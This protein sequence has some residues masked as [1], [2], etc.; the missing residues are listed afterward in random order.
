MSD[1]DAIKKIVDKRLLNDT[2][3]RAHRAQTT[4]LRWVVGLGV[5]VFLVAGVGG[6]RYVV[7]AS[8]DARAAEERNDAQDQ[9]ILAV[10]KRVDDY[11]RQLDRMED[12][13]DRLIERQ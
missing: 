7:K 12:K 6:V 4:Q 8:G 11:S 3:C 10:D 13:L 1:S 9:K 5:S 2:A